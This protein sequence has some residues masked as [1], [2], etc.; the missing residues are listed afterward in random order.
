MDQL[1]GCIA[2]RD[3]HTMNYHQAVTGSVRLSVNPMDAAQM[4]LNSTCSDVTADA[5]TM[6]CA[7]LN[8]HVHITL[9]LGDR[10][11]GGC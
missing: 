1:Q 2:S 6:P 5:R 4:S 8:I 9:Q 3:V 11:R 10:R 7:Q